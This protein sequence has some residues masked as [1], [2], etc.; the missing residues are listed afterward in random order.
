MTSNYAL[1]MFFF[2][3]QFTSSSSSEVIVYWLIYTAAISLMDCKLL[4]LLQNDVKA[5]RWISKRQNLPDRPFT[6]AANSDDDGDWQGHL[7]NHVWLKKC[8]LLP[9][10]TCSATA[11]VD[12]NKHLSSRDCPMGSNGRRRPLSAAEKAELSTKTNST[13]VKFQ[14]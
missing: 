8:K 6:K 11:V 10:E 5:C 9:V 12:E 4:P 14:V 1:I 3:I 7:F 2:W 13:R